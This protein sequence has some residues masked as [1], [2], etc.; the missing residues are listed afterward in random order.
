MCCFLM[1][2]YL[3]KLCCKNTK[4]INHITLKR[5]LKDNKEYQ[6]EERKP[7][8]KADIIDMWNLIECFIMLVLQEDIFG[9]EKH[10]F[11]LLLT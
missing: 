6:K 7:H 8:E 11:M 5:D 9:R 3:F 10:Y 4:S 2:N 1:N